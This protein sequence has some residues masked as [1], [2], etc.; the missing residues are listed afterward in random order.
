MA[1]FSDQVAIVTG[2]SRGIGRVVATEL[3]REGA[4][5]VVAARSQDALEV[6]AD[7]ITAAGGRALPVACDLSDREQ[8]AALVRR[9]AEAFDGLDVVV[10]AAQGA[11][12][13]ACV[14]SYAVG[15]IQRALDSGFFGSL[16]VM[17]AA[18]EPLRS[19]GGGHIVNFGDGDAQVGEPGKLASNV[20]KSAIAALTRTAA[21]EWGRY[22]IYVNLVEPLARTERLLEEFERD[23]DRE[24]WLAGQ[25]PGGEIG[26]PN[27]VARAVLFLLSDDSRML[28]GMSVHVDGGRAMFS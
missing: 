5:V 26:D 20:A 25:V 10:N 24:A 4:A 22:G 23:P 1:R 21:R 12:D 9:A 27:A 17:Q 19:R 7:E 6:L 18:F 14:E 16:A 15:E 3:A 28:T 11:T 13:E 2:A 8:A